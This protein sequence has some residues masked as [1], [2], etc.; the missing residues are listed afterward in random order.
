MQHIQVSM[1]GVVVSDVYH[2]I[3]GDQEW[4]SFRMVSRP[5][6]FDQSQGQMMDGEPSFVS[7]FARRALA[8]NTAA[9]LHRGDPVVVTG[10][11]RVREREF[12]G[13]MRVRVEIDA[14]SIGHD[15]SRGTTLFTRSPTRMQSNDDETVNPERRTVA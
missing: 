7:V 9:S 4:T 1:A 12:E 10:R 11:L 2:S 13:R 14:H 6:R 8:A 15:L 5:R 3:D